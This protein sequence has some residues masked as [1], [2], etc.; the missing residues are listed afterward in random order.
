MQVHLLKEI[1]F[2][3]LLQ[4][5]VYKIQL[6]SLQ[7][8]IM[9]V[10]VPSSILGIQPLLFINHRSSADEPAA[11]PPDFLPPYKGYRDEDGKED[12]GALNT[13]IHEST[14]SPPNR[15]GILSKPESFMQKFSFLA[16]GF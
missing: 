7:Q 8:K 13:I 10:T 5:K 6:P 2:S 3:L 14:S 4:F 12:D 1:G 16:A 9:G 11:S 15:Y